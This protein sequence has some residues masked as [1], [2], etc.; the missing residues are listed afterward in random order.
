M[1]N[2]HWLLVGIVVVQQLNIQLL[3]NKIMAGDF[4]SY[5]RAKQKPKE[6]VIEVEVP[7][8]SFARII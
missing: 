1:D 6:K 4:G 8:E 2:F 7:T 5:T 3:V